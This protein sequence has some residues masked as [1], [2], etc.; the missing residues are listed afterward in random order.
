[1]SDT[2]GILNREPAPPLAEAEFLPKQQLPGRPQHLLELACKAVAASHGGIGL[3]SA[4]GDLIEHVAFGVSEKAS[5]ELW[6]APWARELIGFV[7][8]K[9]VYVQI[10]DLGAQRP[11]LAQPEA[12]PA[13]GP[14]LAVPFVGAARSR[15]A[16][17]LM[18]PPGARPF[19]PAEVQTVLPL[20]GW[21]EQGKLFEE[22]GVLAQLRLLNQVAQ[23]A[24]GSLELP[25]ILA[26]AL[27]ELD[28]HLPLHICA[29]WLVD[30]A[31][32]PGSFCEAG[33]LGNGTP[34]R[35]IETNA[36]PIERAERLGLVPG[37]QLALAD[38]PFCE[39]LS[40]GRAVYTDLTRPEERGDGLMRSLAAR[41]ANASF[42]VP[43]RTGDQTAGVLHSV[44]TRPS[45]F[46]SAQIQL[47][48]LVADLLGPAISNCRLYTRLRDAY[49]ELR[50]TQ[51]QLIQAEKMRALGELASGVAHDFNNSLC[52]ALGFLELTLA[53]PSLT[54]GVRG[55]LES[56]RTCTLDAAHTVRRVQNFARWQRNEITVEV[57]D[58]DEVVRQAVDLTRHKW[59]GQ[60]RSLGIAIE[61]EVRTEAAAR[62]SGSA[63]ELREVL[64]NLIFNAVDA[65]PEGG[66][67]TIRTWST[68]TDVYLSVRDSGL[69]MS[70]SVRRRLFEPFFTTKGERGTGLGLSVTFGIIKR[71]G[72]E[73]TV[74][75]ST[76][77]G[78][79]FVV[80]LPVAPAPAEGP[81]FN[82]PGVAPSGSRLQESANGKAGRKALRVLVIE[83]EESIRRFLQT[84]LTGLGHRAH[85]TSDGEAGL[86][87]FQEEPF[88]VVLTDYGLPGMSG[89]EVA[90][91]VT[92][93][94]PETPVL[95]L[96]GWSSQLQAEEQPLEGVTRILGKP[97]TL[98]ALATAL[99][100]V[101]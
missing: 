35:L 12:L 44:C 48:Y 64:T 42:A 45:G 80:R 93:S 37:M 18:R 47:L 95:L 92:R 32:R 81:D 15:G 51:G 65:M 76:G 96:T 40:Q 27:R 100:A 78:S 2:K 38:S 21:L 66:R 7:L 90:R 28:R 60:A 54:P 1:V 71:Y 5:A 75:S 94:K 50:T 74:D 68:P 52:G 77:Y 101:C 39:C 58:V 33:P 17:Y 70:D 14:F 24:A 4:E 87:A 79:T 57:L 13:V 73:I 25:R 34:L 8:E 91:S 19:S 11:V 26:A 97:V 88:D 36:A 98:Q 62:V 67:L 86:Q 49:E 72:G 85:V 69:G 43:L 16:I 55:Y 9:P 53:D 83:D 22:S 30:E 41:G 99:D 61:V 6:R 10:E 29:V 46:T 20:R 56:A 63:A 59:E 31:A 3:L 84:A 89:E 82:R 23:A